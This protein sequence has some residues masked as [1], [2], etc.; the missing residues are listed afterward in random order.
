MI[1]KLKSKLAQEEMVGF[2]MIIIIV[3]VIMLL[4]LRLSLTK[5]SGEN[6]G[7]Y[8]AENFI[9]GFLQHTTDCRNNQDF[10]NIKKLIFECYNKN[11]CE[12]GRDTC[13]VLNATLSDI[14]KKSWDISE[15]SEYKGYK[16]EIYSNEESVMNMSE[17]RLA[18]N[19]KGANQDFS[20]SGSDFQIFLTVYTG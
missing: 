17:G 3:A 9:F 1:K 6:I 20:R 18:G 16:L 19:N 4:F 12:D 5:N 14:V 13:V 2:A 11:E 15:G 8:E 7:S 10:M